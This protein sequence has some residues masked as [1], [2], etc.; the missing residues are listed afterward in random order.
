MNF[1]T[2]Q[3]NYSQY[4]YDQLYLLDTI[5]FNSKDIYSTLL[6][7][8]IITENNELA[9]VLINNKIRINDNGKDNINAITL[10]AFIGNLDLL[11]LLIENGIDIN[12]I[13]ENNHTS[14]TIASKMGHLEI[15]EYL[16]ENGANI[17]HITDN[18]STALIYASIYN[19][20]ECVKLLLKSG[21]NVNDVNTDNSSALVYATKYNNKKIIY[22]LLNEDDI[23][24][25][26]IDNDEYSPLLYAIQNKNYK[27]VKKMVDN[28]ADIE[29]KTGP[30]FNKYNSI[31]L[32]NKCGYKTI[33][34]LLTKEKLKN[35]SDKSIIND[36]VKRLSKDKNE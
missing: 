17:N 1:L 4:T 6:M 10:C 9:R 22:M 25:N 34:K 13:G 12:T 31:D 27:A 20:V 36:F 5:S 2:S 18:N 26:Q 33:S 29:Y 7:K 30:I 21:A 19:N 35:R 24:I 16:I 8:S 28:G 3:T 32:A 14:L 23:Y 15:V 11:K